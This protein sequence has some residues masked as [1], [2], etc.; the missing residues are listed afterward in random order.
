MRKILTF[1]L[2]LFFVLSVVSCSDY[3]S[4]TTSSSAKLSFSSDSVMFDTLIASV[5]SS[6][7]T[8]Y[9]FNR[10]KDGVRVSTASLK[11]GSQS[12]FR[13]N[14]DGRFLY[15]GSGENFPIWKKDSILVRIE[16]TMPET[17]L[18]DPVKYEDD[19]I[20]QLE[21]GVVQSVHL[22]ASAIDGYIV[23]GMIIEEDTE[24]KTDKP[25]IIYDS[26]VVK[27]GCQLTLREGTTLM[28]HDKAALDVYGTLVA[29]GSL[30]KPVTLRGDRMDH[31]FDYLKYDNTPSRW[32]GVHIHDG[33]SGNVLKYVDL[34]S[35]CYGIVCDSVGVD[36]SRFKGNNIVSPHLRL[37]NCILHN[38]G[39]DG[40]QINNNV[41]EVYNTQ[42]SNTLGHCVNINGGASKFA[43][44]TIA[45]FYPFSANRGF[46]LNI[47]SVLDEGASHV[48]MAHFYNCVITGYS[49]DVIMGDIVDSQDF[50]CNYLFKNCYLNTVETDDED[51][52]VKVIYDT[53]K[54]PFLRDENFKVFD[55]KNFIYDFT[56]KDSSSIRNFADKTFEMDYDNSLFRFD[57]LG[58][59]RLLDETPDVGC[60]EFIAE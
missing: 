13:V 43:H 59:D 15:N 36:F 14:V 11:K 27:N 46:A 35:G 55:S 17:G 60:Y 49:D 39:G 44:C 56:P 31:M 20:F 6:T 25:Y 3:A 51:R 18:I 28:F 41:V 57:R 37:E 29:N 24:L 4:F 9:V 1:C 30:E 7:K 38:L 16:V 34:H 53:D 40:L 23:H 42:I 50:P 22:E 21:S 45:Q 48:Y 58:R 10:N 26:L 12:P 8:L 33:S 2:L 52:F 32:E 54:Q 47:V 5:P 19:L